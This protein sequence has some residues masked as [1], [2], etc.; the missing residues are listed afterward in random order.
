MIRI[1]LTALALL[2]TGCTSVSG[3]INALA[4]DDAS[5][6]LTVVTM[7]GTARLYRTKVVNGSVKCSDDGLAVTSGAPT[8]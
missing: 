6:C 7:S 5:V 1:L 2:L 3:I 4:K 8:P